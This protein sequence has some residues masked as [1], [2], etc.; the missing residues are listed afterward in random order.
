MHI[1]DCDVGPEEN[2]SW[3]YDLNTGFIRN[4]YNPNKCIHKQDAWKNGT[5][6][7]LW[8]CNSGINDNKSWL[9]PMATSF[10]K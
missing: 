1:W 7:H 2:K 5:R 3:E 9:Q 4:R 10:I 6:I 8:D